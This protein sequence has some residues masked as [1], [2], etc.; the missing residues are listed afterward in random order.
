M[1]AGHVLGMALVLAPAV[2]LASDALDWLNRAA[3]ASHTL[4]YTGV[5]V[6]QHGDHVEMLQV[7]QR[8]DAA[9]EKNKVEVIDGP[10]RVFLRLND[11]VY[12][13]S[14]DGKTVRLEKGAAR[15]F[16]P[17]VLPASPASLLDYYAPQIGGIEHIAGRECQAIL[18][19]PRDDYRFSHA[20]CLDR[21]TGLPL[22]TATINDMGAPV[23]SSTFTEVDIGRTPDARLFVPRLAG[24]RLETGLTGLAAS[25]WEI[26]P[27]PGYVQVME[28]HRPLLGKSQPVT[29]MVFSDGLGAVSVFIEPLPNML[30]MEGLST[31]GSIGIYARRVGVLKVT[32]VGEAPAAALIET[33]NSIRPK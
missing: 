28:S 30:H 33:G 31:E 20:L 18:L 3:Q 6:Y 12:C 24:K 15:R 19:Q 1:I 5:Y 25:A 4:N 10:H 7:T 11:E 9:G 26:T 29:Q 14:A 13:H 22:K 2:A 21:Q 27:P 16:F 32:T 23:S 17:S 8:V